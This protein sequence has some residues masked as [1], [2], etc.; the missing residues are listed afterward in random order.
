M[1]A[2]FI[3]ELA[4]ILECD[5]TELNAD[6]IFRDHP[7]WDSLAVLS[8]MSMIDETFDVL[9]KQDEFANLKTIGD[10]VACIEAKKAG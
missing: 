2:E 5:A 4:N 9:I 7:N 1:H 3:Q 10:I 8:T 6:I